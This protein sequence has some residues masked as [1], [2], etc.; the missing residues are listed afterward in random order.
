MEQQEGNTHTHAGRTMGNKS[1]APAPPA[2]GAA[3]SPPS[4]PAAAAQ[5]SPSSSAISAT[6]QSPPPP[7]KATSVPEFTILTD[8]QLMD[9]I[10][11][12]A[13]DVNPL[14]YHARVPICAQ[15]PFPFPRVHHQSTN[16]PLDP[17]FTLKVFVGSDAHSLFLAKP[18][19]WCGRG[20]CG[21]RAYVASQVY[22]NHVR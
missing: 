12:N 10:G 4:T 6:T 22:V 9:Q 3:A 21:R 2:A 17:P 18:C 7:P 8:A 5:S 20:R 13:L 1:S 11:P 15:Y 14:W 16:S 19:V